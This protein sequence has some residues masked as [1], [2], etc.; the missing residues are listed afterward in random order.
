MTISTVLVIGST[1]SIGRLVVAE[2]LAQGYQ[3]RA[4]VRDAERARQILP[5]EADLA[6]GDVTRPESLR[7]VIR[8]VDAAILT[9]GVEGDEEKIEAVSYRGVRDLRADVGRRGHRPNRDVQHR[10]PGGLEAPR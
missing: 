6:A 5:A 3:V 7:E 8:G 9:H 4:L 1:G 10:Q 2:A